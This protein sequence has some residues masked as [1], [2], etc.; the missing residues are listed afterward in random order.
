MYFYRIV[1]FHTRR[2]FRAR[3]SARIS[4]SGQPATNDRQFC[5]NN[6]GHKIYRCMPEHSTRYYMLLHNPKILH[7][8]T[9]FAPSCHLRKKISSKKKL[10]QSSLINPLLTHK[11]LPTSKYDSNT[12]PSQTPPP[13]FFPSLG[14]G[15]RSNQPLACNR[16]ISLHT[17]SRAAY[18]LYLYVLCNY[19][20][21]NEDGGV[22]DNPYS[23][24]LFHTNEYGLVLGNHIQDPQLYITLR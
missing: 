17:N 14:L 7:T 23:L 24:Q 18:Y 11:Q 6:P 10:S 8:K 22:L 21:T 15:L 19:Y 4:D 12:N 9:F 1:I 3:L 20:H 13:P 5:M 2:R 16:Y